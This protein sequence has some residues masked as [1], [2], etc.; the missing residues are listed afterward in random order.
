MSL[1]RYEPLRSKPYRDPVTGDLH[2]EVI[3][4]DGEC[5]AARL[6]FV[7]ECSDRNG[8]RHASTDLDRLTVEHVKD[9]SRMGKRAPSDAAHLVALCYSRNVAVPSRAMREA[10]RAYLLEGI[11]EPD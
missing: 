4:R 6:G 3:L 7:H 11:G 1:R 2:R 9:E 10:F 8:Y 5:L